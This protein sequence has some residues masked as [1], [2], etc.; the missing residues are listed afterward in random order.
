M[1]DLLKLVVADRWELARVNLSDAR[2]SS[3]QTPP[4]YRLVISSAYYAMYHGFRAAAFLYHEGDDHQD[5]DKL[6]NGIPS[7]LPNQLSWQNSLK[8]ARL[9]RN[10]A[11]YDPYPKSNLAWRGDATVALTSAT[12]ALKE[13][14]TYLNGKG[15]TI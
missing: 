14:R 10:R 8:Q 9:A 1:P 3:I 2:R 11:D 6:P 13:I 15:C 4:R 7:D 12:D 5:H